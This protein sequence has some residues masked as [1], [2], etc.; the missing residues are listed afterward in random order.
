MITPETK[1]DNL[2][3]LVQGL[4]ARLERIEADK[5]PQHQWLSTKEISLIVGV[6]VRTVQNWIRE[7]K[8]PKETYCRKKRGK[9]YIYKFDKTLAV[10]V[11]EKLKRGEYSW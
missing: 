3:G 8:F 10:S 7:D 4:S 1:L 2:I 9:Y 11:A 5:L 6:T